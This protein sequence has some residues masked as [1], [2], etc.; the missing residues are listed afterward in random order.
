MNRPT[1]QYR[2]GQYRPGQYQSGQYRTLVGLVAGLAFGLV[3]TGLA[4][5]PAHAQKRATAGPSKAVTAKIIDAVAEEIERAKALLRVP[6]E[7]PPYFIG[8]KLTEVDVNDA[9]ASLGATTW[10]KN[11]HFVSLDARVHVGNY[12][13]DN[14]NFVVA[15]FEATD[16]LAS[17]TLPVEATPRIARRVAWLVTDAAYKEALEQMRAKEDTQ[18]AGGGVPAGSKSYLPGIPEV[19]EESVDVPILEK[20]D[21]LEMRAQKISKIFRNHKHI[22]DS[23]VAFTSFLERRWYL[24]SEGTSV[25]DTR[26]V[27]GVLIAA[28]TQADDGQELAL[29]YTRYG[30]TAAD[31]PGDAVLAAEAD[32]LAKNLDALRKAPVVDSYVGPVLFE[33][34]GAVDIARHTLATQLGGTPLPSGLSATEAR[35]FGGGLGDRVGQRVISPLLSVIDDPTATRHRK[36]ALIGGYRFDDEGVAAKRVSV[37]K[38]GKLQTLLSSRT[39]GK[40]VTTSNGHARRAAGGVYHGSATNLAIVGKRGQSRKQ[41]VRKLL[42][43]ARGLGLKYGIIIRRLD[44]PAATALPELSMRELFQMVKTTDPAAPP[45]AALAYRVYPNGT[46][47]LVRG[48][49]LR[50]VEL[51]AWR[52]IIAVGKGVQVSNFLASGEHHINHK[53]R[54]VAEGSVPSSGVESS[55]V[56]PDLLFR[57]LDITGSTA[58]R[59]KA[60][61]V[62]RPAAN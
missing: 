13:N 43:E 8:Q 28:T 18:G 27:S 9:V 32:K 45:I 34:E 22:R 3:T 62:P 11:R 51:R 21:A 54:G 17:M 31:L 46:E 56:T 42:A 26:R 35:H 25:H 33:G 58:G 23:R 61:L 41:L 53:L 29:H 60:P 49:Q 36:R 44:D 14:S 38:D 19:K 12:A 55:I 5:G 16:G 40:G 20:L 24:N 7:L 10:K 15:N 57:E 50:E 1:S 39:P 37:I 48:V 2:P 4:S 6:N 30:L 52:D 59:R 47:E